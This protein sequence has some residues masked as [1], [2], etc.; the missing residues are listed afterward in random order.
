MA[1]PALATALT[2]Y[3]ALDA[4][5]ERCD[6]PDLDRLRDAVSA[7]KRQYQA[8][9]YRE[10]TA[11]LPALLSALRAAVCCRDGEDRRS[12]L[13]LSAEAHQVAASILLKI[14]DAGLAGIAAERSMQAAE[15]SESLLAIGSS[16]RAVTHTLMDSGHTERAATFAVQAARAMHGQCHD[17][18][19]LL[20]VYGSLLLRG[21]AAA[22]NGQNRVSALGLLDEADEVASRIGVDG[23]HYWTTFGP[24]NVLLHRVNL[25]VKLGD[26]GAAIFHAK[27]I[28]P[29]AVDV[30]ERR[31]MLFID[32]ARAFA[33]WRKYDRA[34]LALHR[35]AAIAP[36]EIGRR[37]S[38]LRLVA[39][40]ADAAPPST[41]TQVRDLTDRVRRVR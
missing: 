13:A 31:A 8:C 33:L 15:A 37:V 16:A 39:E 40:I 10:V 12:L 7:A 3:S 19:R 21:A 35:A 1:A 26:P 29:R 17:E 5:P 25:A 2:S 34:Y 24:T 28:D 30:T 14:G 22:A 9:R 41:A 11:L 18:P 4:R 20:S 6:R 27:R 23:N 38:V 32:V 36:E